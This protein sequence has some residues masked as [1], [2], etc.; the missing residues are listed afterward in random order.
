[1]SRDIEFRG[2]HIHILKENEKLNGTWVYGYLCDK[3]Y[4]FSEELGGDM[5]V[6]KNTIGQYTGL[7]DKNGKKIFE[8]DIVHYY[9]F[10]SVY[11][12]EITGKVIYSQDCMF[13]IE[14]DDEFI[15]NH[16]TTRP[17]VCNEHPIFAEKKIEVIGNIYENNLESKGE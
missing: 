1:M 12:R 15:K 8:G 16:K 4:I 17:L 14:Y 11:S 9:D 7:K 5:L 3:S 6:D 13:K 2:K 10:T